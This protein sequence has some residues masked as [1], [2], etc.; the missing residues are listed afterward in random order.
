MTRIVEWTEPFSKDGNAAVVCRMTMDDVI[1]FQMTRDDGFRYTDPQRAFEDF[2]TVRWA[3]V[4]NAAAP[5]WQTCAQA[6]LAD[7]RVLQISRAHASA[8]PKAENP[9]WRNTHH[10]LGY[11][12]RVLERCAR[13]EFGPK[14]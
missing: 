5:D 1:H 6:I 3:T 11:V 4:K 2:V 9:A 12:L 14:P 10:D 8:R 13:G 7:E